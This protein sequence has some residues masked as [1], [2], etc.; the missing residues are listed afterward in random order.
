MSLRTDYEA[1]KRAYH[2]T[3]EALAAETRAPERAKLRREYIE[4]HRHYVKLGTQLK[5]KGR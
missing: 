4:A 2:R 1:A 3:G 5:K